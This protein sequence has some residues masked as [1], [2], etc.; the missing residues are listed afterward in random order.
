MFVKFQHLILIPVTL[1]LAPLSLMAAPHCSDTFKIEAK[2]VSTIQIDKALDDLARMKIQIDT[3]TAEGSS[4][5]STA[6]S[7]INE[8]TFE[9]KLTEVLSVL[10]VKTTRDEFIEKIKLKIKQ[11]QDSNSKT[12]EVIEKQ[13]RAKE[14]VVIEKLK[15][16]EFTRQGRISHFWTPGHMFYDK[17]ADAIFIVYMGG[18]V[19]KLTWHDSQEVEF[20]QN[21]FGARALDDGK[22]MISYGKP[23]VIQRHDLATGKL[24]R[25]IKA[26]EYEFEHVTADVSPKGLTYALGNGSDK[27]WVMDTQTGKEIL[28]LSRED[29]G[30]NPNHNFAGVEFLSEELLSIRAYGGPAVST[31][32]IYNIK[33]GQH[34]AIDGR[35]GSGVTL[36]ADG[37]LLYVIYDTVT[38]YDVADMSIVEKFDTKALSS[39]R[40]ILAVP[41]PN[42]NFHVIASD[43]ATS[44]PFAYLADIRSD[45][46]TPE[47]MLE[48]QYYK[49][50]ILKHFDQTDRIFFSHD[51]KTMIVHA[52]RQTANGATQHI[53]DKWERK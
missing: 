27:V 43:G 32:I 48:S 49:S 50:N 16:P 14:D 9:T 40:G 22:S 19:G 11:S 38:I 13:A 24:I 52:E 30:K 4:P 12:E 28:S 18:K 41:V 2:E 8:S 44:Q 21:M 5:D 6:L 53:I 7:T 51:G 33:S 23:G 26:P 35:T 29:I 17:K 37:K 25:S 10:G 42:S 46:L 45:I 20:G 31:W 15:V 1:A 3:T 39:R 47:N 36:S 34:Y